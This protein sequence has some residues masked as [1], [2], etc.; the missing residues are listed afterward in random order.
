M[1]IRRILMNAQDG[2]PGSGA[3]PSTPATPAIPAEPAAPAPQSAPASGSPIDIA[4][5]T[6]TIT[7][8]VT[9]SINDGVFAK[10]RRAGLLSDKP[11]TVPVTGD[12]TTTA[13][14]AAISAAD[15]QSMIEQASAITRVSVEYGL[16]PDAESSLKKLMSVEKPD[17]PV[18]WGRAFI[19]GL[20]IKKTASAPATAAPQVT[21]TAPSTAAP[22]ATQPPAPA[23]ATPISDRGSPPPSSLPLDERSLY[24]MSQADVQEYIKRH[25][26]K[27]YSEKLI[28][29]A[30]GKRTLLR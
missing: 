25:G 5:I 24:E 6:R 17:D 1:L 8:S 20:G 28:A 26:M 10:L 2:S 18:A 7:E 16:Q 19:E 21:T 30:K 9:K 3:T 27:K 11:T 15:V 29:D 12:T 22:A 23:A 13:T 4:A 14:A